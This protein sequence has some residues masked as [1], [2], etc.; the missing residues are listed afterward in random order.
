M[1]YR[2]GLGK[3]VK[4]AEISKGDRNIIF[5]TWY[6]WY[7]SIGNMDRHIICHTLRHEEPHWRDDINGER[8][9]DEQILKQKI[10]TKSS[11]EAEVVRTSNYIP[12]IVWGKRF[13]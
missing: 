9:C 7:R 12:N 13:L 1:Q 10:N 2:A 4:I 5:G 11:T 6:E 3:T 8:S